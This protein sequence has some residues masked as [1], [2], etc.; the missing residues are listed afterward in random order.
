MK[1]KIIALLLAIFCFAGI[2]VACDSGNSE[3]NTTESKDTQNNENTG[4]ETVLGSG[5]ETVTEEIET[6]P[7]THPTIEK[8]NYNDT[9]FVHVFE[10]PNYLWVE[11]SE[12]D[13]FSEAL[14]ARQQQLYEYLH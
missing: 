12:G 9:L 11:E 7:E 10:R 8:Q 5:S 2:L 4:N 14:F 13:V 3:S 6:R 1:I